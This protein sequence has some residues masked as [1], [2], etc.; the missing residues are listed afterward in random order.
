MKWTATH[1][2][3]E[4][5]YWLGVLIGLDQ[6]V[7]ALWPGADIDKTISHRIGVR[8]RK[9]GGKI[10]FWRHPLAAAIDYF[11]E[12]IDPGHSLRSIGY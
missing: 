7:G 9:M 10:P 11:L 1:N 5:P 4:I 6:F 12:K 8:K 3:K 2:G